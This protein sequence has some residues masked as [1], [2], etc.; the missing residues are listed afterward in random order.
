VT[1]CPYRFRVRSSPGPR[2]A[3]SLPCE[4]R[5]PGADALSGLLLA[6]AGALRAEPPGVVERIEK[7]G[8]KVHRDGPGR[9]VDPVLLPQGAT[10]ADLAG[11]CELR[12]LEMLVVHGTRPSSVSLGAVAGL[13][14]VRRLRLS[15]NNITAGVGCAAWTR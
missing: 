14:R 1:G 5:S 3:S 9:P 8:G 10:D 12:G 2:R 13:P 7:A 6:T 11:L 15:G 4:T